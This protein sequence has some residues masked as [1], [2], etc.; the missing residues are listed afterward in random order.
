[1]DA[2][3]P[4]LGP[5]QRNPPS[6]KKARSCSHNRSDFC[7][8]CCFSFIMKPQRRHSHRLSMPN[9]RWTA[10][11]AAGAAT[12]AVIVPTAEA[13]IHYSGIVNYKFDGTNQ[14]S[15]AYFPL[16]PGAS[17]F[18]QHFNLFHSGAARMSL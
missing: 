8:G 16:D 5:Q 9:S 18:L 17:I 11:A 4:H 10:Y 12:A 15:S 14:V 13:E 7:D 2:D 1:M 3:L 6:R